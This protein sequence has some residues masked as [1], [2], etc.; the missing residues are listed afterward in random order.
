MLGLINSDLSVA[1][2]RVALLAY[3]LPYQFVL[4]PFDSPIYEPRK[5]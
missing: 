1:S 3:L 5:Q 2:P 4:P